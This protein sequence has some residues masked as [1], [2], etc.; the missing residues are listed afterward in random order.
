VVDGHADEPASGTATGRRPALNIPHAS[1]SCPV[2]SRSAAVAVDALT[3]T[4]VQRL[5]DIMTRARDHMRTKP[6]R[7]ATSRNQRK[8]D[9]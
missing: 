2:T 3:A 9:S 1:M 5:T 6:P 7:S 4:D 8:D